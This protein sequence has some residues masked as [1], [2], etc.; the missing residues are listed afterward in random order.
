[1]NA[2]S[3]AKRTPRP[4]FVGL[5]LYGFSLS[6]A[7]LVLLYAR[8]AGLLPMPEAGMDQEAML[9]AAAG[10]YRGRCPAKATSIPPFTRPS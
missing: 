10:I 7:L 4:R 9:K 5:F 6:V 8:Q 3:S 2:P 1:M